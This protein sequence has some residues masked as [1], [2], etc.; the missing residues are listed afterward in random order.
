MRRLADV[1]TIVAGWLGLAK[2]VMLGRLQAHVPHF[3]RDIFRHATSSAKEI[4]ARANGSRPTLP[5]FD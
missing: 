2:S 4:S 1:L 5:R 3:L